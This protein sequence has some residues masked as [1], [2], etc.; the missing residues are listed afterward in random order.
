MDV[1]EIYRHAQ[2][3][4]DANGQLCPKYLVILAAPHN[5][6]IVVRLLPSRYDGI[7]PEQPPCHHGDPYPGYFLGVPGEPLNR[8]TWLDLRPF[9]D[10][11]TADLQRSRANGLLTLICR[12]A[13]AQ[14]RALLQCA[15]AAD[16][17]TRS[18]EAR[19]RDAL[20]SLI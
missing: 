20:A 6:D 14:L 10:L 17:T 8:K 9:D 4:V 19:I 13:G 5:D 18:Q 15:A 7:R 11:D 16:D 3:Y 1:G 12:L 2:F